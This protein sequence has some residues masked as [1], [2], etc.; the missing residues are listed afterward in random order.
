MQRPSAKYGRRASSSFAAQYYAQT[1]PKT[2]RLEDNKEYLIPK[3][4][5][6]GGESTILSDLEQADWSRL[7]KLKT[8][9]VRKENDALDS[10]K[11]RSSAKVE[12]QTP[13]KKMT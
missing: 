13:G 5:V 12:V 3:S 11:T 10:A 2:V 7:I 4:G 9:F 8:S 6:D 1:T